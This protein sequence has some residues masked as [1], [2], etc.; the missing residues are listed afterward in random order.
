MLGY[1]TIGTNDLP[2]AAA[3]YDAIAV[4][5]DGKRIMENDQ[6][7]AWGPADGSP[8]FGVTIP[9]DGQR[10]TPG[11]GQMIALIAEDRSHVDRIYAL[12]LSLGATDAGAPGERFTGLYAGF[13]R[14]LDGN[15]VNVF[16]M[17]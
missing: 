10:A 5:M 9:F 6:F 12:A 17:G 16:M 8:G 14:D 3:F 7:I 2:R 1:V 4:E 15:K 11:N 13:F